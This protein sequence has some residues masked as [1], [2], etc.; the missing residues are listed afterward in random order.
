MKKTYKNRL[1]FLIKNELCIK[2]NRDGVFCVITIF[3][4]KPIS[5]GKTPAEAIDNAILKYREET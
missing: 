5:E 1:Y 4:R 2:E 3:A